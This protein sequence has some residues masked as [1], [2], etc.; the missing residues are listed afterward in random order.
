MT[1]TGD[2]KFN[3]DLGEEENEVIEKYDEEFFIFTFP[4][5]LFLMIF[6]GN[7]ICSSYPPENYFLNVFLWFILWVCFGLTLDFI[8]LFAKILLHLSFGKRSCETLKYYVKR[9]KSLNKIFIFVCKEKDH[10]HCTY[11]IADGCEEPSH[12]G[13]DFCLKHCPDEDHKNLHPPYSSLAT[14][15]DAFSFALNKKLKEFH[16]KDDAAYSVR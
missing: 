2:I 16:E 8:I 1:M 14:I 9:Y 13:S 10:G 12:E 4:F 11:V 3:I 7:I 15:A 5:I 6:A